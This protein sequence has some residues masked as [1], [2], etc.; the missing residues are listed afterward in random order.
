MLKLIVAVIALALASPAQALPY[1]TIQTPASMVTN[2]REAC[3][4]GFHRVN[5]VC[6]RNVKV[7]PV[8][9]HLEGGRCV[10]N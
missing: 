7:C 2:V 5:G 10:R 9:L 1:G 8:G 6:V 4:A 3:G